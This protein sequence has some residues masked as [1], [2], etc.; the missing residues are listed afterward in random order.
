MEAKTQAQFE[1]RAKIIKAMAHPTRLFIVDELSRRER[2]VCELTEMTGI[3]GRISGIMKTTEEAETVLVI[4]GCPF[5]CAKKAME[6]A[7]F[8]QFKHLRL[9]DLGIEKGKS[10][11]TDERVDQVVQEAKTVL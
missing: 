4:D 9:A 11:V 7:G 10:P 3:G 2:C 6:T 8:T 5:H 1:A